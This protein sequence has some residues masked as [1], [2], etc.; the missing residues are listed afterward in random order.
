MIYRIRVILDV[1]DDVF[2]DIEIQGSDTLEDLHEAIVRSFDLDGREMASFYLSDDEWNQGEEIT[3]FDLSDG[4]K[5]TK[6]MSRFRIDEVLTGTH[7]RLLYAYDFMNIR[8]FYV[9]VFSI[10][11]PQDG[12]EYPRVVLSY[13]STPQY[14]DSDME[15][16]DDP[17]AIEYDD[18]DFDDGFSERGDDIFAGDEAFGGSYGYDEDDRY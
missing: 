2:R 8:T 11:P 13:G 17:D 9:E 14:T 3:L 16:I 10:T 18:E 15:E 4:D 6:V 12:V 1:R 7:Q 5:N